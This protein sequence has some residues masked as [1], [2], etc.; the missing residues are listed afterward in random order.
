MGGDE[1]YM[2]QKKSIVQDL[3]SKRRI[4]KVLFQKSE[5]VGNSE[6]TI[7]NYQFLI[8]ELTNNSNDIE[9]GIAQNLDKENTFSFYLA[10][11]SGVNRG[12]FAITFSINGNWKIKGIHSFGL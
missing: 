3:K 12:Y 5:K 8:R 10:T 9:F 6:N 4:Y 1:D 7:S 2:M 11:K